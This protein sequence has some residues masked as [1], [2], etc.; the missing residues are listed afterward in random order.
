MKFFDSAEWAK[1]HLTNPD[2]QNQFK[3]IPAHLNSQYSSHL[4]FDDSI[5]DTMTSSNETEINLPEIQPSPLV[6]VTTL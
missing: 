2:R 4:S 5:S 6:V 1:N 3:E